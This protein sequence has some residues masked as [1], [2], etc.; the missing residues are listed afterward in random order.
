M[1][2]HLGLSGSSL[3]FVSSTAAVCF[4][5]G[6]WDSNIS[7]LHDYKT[8]REDFLKHF[9]MHIW[10]RETRARKRRTN[11]YSVH[12]L[13]QILSQVIRDDISL[14]LASPCSRFCL[15][16]RLEKKYS[17]WEAILGHT[18]RRVKKAR[19]AEMGMW[20]RDYHSGQWRPCRVDTPEGEP[21]G[22]WAGHS[23]TQSGNDWSCTWGH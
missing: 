3:L 13:F 5:I 16:H 20:W 22:R 8:V 2:S 6:L 7:Y 12:V 23:C 21:S 9:I 1:A 11:I 10:L 18:S 17:I 4:L 15:R 19:K 14:R